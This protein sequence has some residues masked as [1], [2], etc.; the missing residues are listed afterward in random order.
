MLGTV[1]K[2]AFRS[3]TTKR[4]VASLPILV[5]GLV[6]VSCGGP[7]GEGSSSPQAA[8]LE[9]SFGGLSRSALVHLPPTEDGESPMAVVLVF[10]GGG[11]TAEGIERI[12]HFD[13]VADQ[14]N[15]VAVYP[16]GYRKSWADGRG[17][18]PAER[19]EVNNVG[20]VG[21]L[22]DKLEQQHKVDKQRIFA[23]GLSNG[24]FFSQRLGCDLSDRIAAIA[25]VAGTQGSNFAPSCQPAYP[26]SLLE[27]HGTDDPLV[28]Y[29]G[30]VM[31]GR[32]GKSSIL[33][34]EDVASNWAAIDGCSTSPTTNHVPDQVDDGTHLVIRVYPNCAA[35]TAV[36][37]Y[38]VDG[39]GHTWPGGE[40]YFSA[41]IIG[42]STGQ[43]DASEAIWEF[44]T[45]HPML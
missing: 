4:W 12:S 8:Q 38:E 18:T 25:P 7:S 34:A 5:W 14:N 10:H 15:F 20:F 26:V 17:T 40:Q 41:A 36:E 30:G 2:D 19:A 37:L 33:S 31:H 44:F 29:Q 28:P 22:L 6:L 23:T 35:N 1:T 16:Q 13:S 39:G 27:I 11:G 21:A 3:W 43:F 9:F 24:A 45:A 32:G 42:K